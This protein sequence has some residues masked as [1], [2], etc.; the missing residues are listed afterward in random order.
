MIVKMI[1]LDWKSMKV[2]Q[3]RLL[4]LPV[5]AFAICWI[6]SP[7]LTIPICVFICLAFSVNPFAVEEKGDLN[8]MYL[9]LPIKR[10][11]IVAGRYIFSIIMFMCGVTMGILLLPLVNLVS[12]SKWYLN[13]QWY[14]AVISVSYALYSLFN[15]FM[16]PLLFK[17]G[18][19]KAKVIGFYIP[20]ILFSMLFSLYL[21]IMSFP[22]NAYLATNFL[23]FAGNNMLLVC[24]CLIAIATAILILSYILSVR[25]YLKRDF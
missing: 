12:N 9:T 16:F 17:F 4:L 13:F 21:V 6:V 10:N 5:F 19:L 8:G 2:Y 14:L 11:T 24:G 15:I 20:M 25:I 3:M 1:I 7:L 23:I 22:K 18:Y